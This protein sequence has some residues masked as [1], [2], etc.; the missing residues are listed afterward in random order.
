MKENQ[1]YVKR[2]GTSQ[3]KNQKRDFIMLPTVDF[4]FKELMQNENVRK[5][6]VSALL[7]VSPE[8]VEG[9]ELMPTILRKQYE[10]DKYGV[11]DVRVRLKNGTQIDFEMQVI[12]FDY[13]ANRTIYYLSK[14]YIEQI[15]EGDEYDELQKCIHVSILDHV[16]FPQ[17]QECY[18][19]VTF[20]D[21]ET[22]D[23]Y[24]D[25]M[26]I[27][28]LELPKL[29]AE[30]KNETDLMQWMR[31]LG[32]KCRED[33][34]KMVEKNS[35]FKEAYNVLDKLSTDEEKRMEYEARQKA[36]RDYNAMMKT[37]ERR[38]M[39]SGMK[40]GMEEGIEKGMEEG[41]EK[42]IAAMIETYQEFHISR[43]DAIKRLIK[44]FDITEMKSKK[45]INRY[46]KNAD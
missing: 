36:I 35:C 38:G 14:M 43:E 46:W 24:S 28:I 22:G 31:F 45:Y 32:G 17:D 41:I 37:A 15:K 42:G 18:R 30:Q 20:C 39:E 5:G 9:T 33:F 4:C 40:K 25:L 23:E 2:E 19:R 34:E 1:N 12:C 3:E 13:W 10:D 8:E 6:I 21:T 7:K 44:Q 27:H 29:P 16:Y 26:E 11:L